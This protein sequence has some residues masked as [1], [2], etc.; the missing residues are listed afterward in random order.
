MVVTA[1][2]EARAA[3]FRHFQLKPG[4]GDVR[5]ID[6]EI[7]QI[8][9]V[10]ALR[11]SDEDVIV[12]ANANWNLSE[13][14]RAVQALRDLP[15]V[16]EQ[17]CRSWDECLAVRKH[18]PGRIKL[19]E[20]IET[21]RDVIRAA[22][23][24]FD[25]VAI[26]IARVGGLSKAKLLRDL[27]LDLGLAVVPDDA[28]GSQIVSSALLHLAASTDPRNTLCFT[29]LT[30]YVDQVSADG[31]PIRQGGRIAAPSAPGLGLRPRLEVLGPP[32]AVIQ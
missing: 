14:M 29:D 26:K 8:Q 30:D 15:V 9:A 6:G 16:L 28:W 23:H 13:A 21:P 12:D 22:R 4:K 32:V 7:E 3:G 1:C 24:G 2:K 5:T 25:I 17:P 27:A 20:L 10:A 31:F 19:D 18:W 11:H